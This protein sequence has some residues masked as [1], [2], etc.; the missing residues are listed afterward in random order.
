MDHLIV[1]ISLFILMLAG[2]AVM[3][4]S[5]PGNFISVIVALL[6]LIFSDQGTITIGLFILILGLVLSGEILEQLLGILGAK[7]FG[8][9][10]KGILGAFIGALA[11]GIIGSLLF[12]VIGTII[13]VFI[14]CF[15][16]T[17]IFEYY[18]EKKDSEESAKAGV[19]A[20]IGKIVAVSYKYGVG[21]IILII[22]VIRFWVRKY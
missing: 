16:L 8:A 1:E 17:F 3:I 15:I 22:F 12:P 5:I 2:V 19:G 6:Y 11:G 7:K 9:S 14:G 18:L 21:F 13:G 4:F 10:K 20:M